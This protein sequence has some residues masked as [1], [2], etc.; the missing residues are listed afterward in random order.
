MSISERLL[1]A[2]SRSPDAPD[3]DTKPAGPWVPDDSL[4]L[5]QRVYPGFDGLV[6]DR[7]ILDFGCGDGEQVVALAL[8][9]AR[10]VVG[11]DTNPRV[12]V[13]A[14]KLASE[15]GVTDRVEFMEVL[16]AERQGTFDLVV[17]QNSM[18]HIP[19]PERLFTLMQDALAPGGALLVTFGPPWYAPYGSHAQYFTKVPWVNLLFSER[20]VLAVRSRF[21]SDGATRYEDIE[22]GLNR[23]SVARFE[24]IVARSG[25]HVRYRH[26]DYSKGLDFVRV[27]PGV[28]ELFTS[29][30]SYILEKPLSEPSRPSPRGSV[31]AGHR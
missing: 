12:L 25:M 26:H 30:V 6:R 21:R 4:R 11:V 13:N 19:E 23:M 16:P 14:R 28:R 10:R 9:G 18:E 17:S 15:H 22:G 2:L 7:T 1:L 3:Y 5:L 31:A 27:I 29:H 8:R 20:T 24:R